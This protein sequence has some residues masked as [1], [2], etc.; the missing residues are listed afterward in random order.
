ME[1]PLQQHPS[2]GAA[3]KRLGTT[4]EQ[5]NINGAAPTQVIRRFGINF[6]PRGPIWN[7]ENPDALRR[8][9]LR[10]INAEHPSDIYRRAG[11]RQ[12]MTSAHVAELNLRGTDWL[13]QANGKWRNAWRKSQKSKLKLQHSIFDAGLHEWLLSE[14]LNQQRRKKYRALPHSI[15]RSYA[16]ISPQDVLV[17]SAKKNREHVAAMVFLRHGSVATYHLGWTDPEGRTSNAH[18]A[19]LMQA[20]DFFSTKGVTRLDLGAV[21]TDNAP[22][23]ARFKIGCGAQV[24]LLGGTWLRIPGF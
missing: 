2:F 23:L 6:A 18:Y 17:F 12:L 22:G 21:D 19:L 8:S 24:R 15:I 11:F 13:A 20:A 9:P 14:D 16:K 7:V 1:M 3:L 4:V 5:I 10:I